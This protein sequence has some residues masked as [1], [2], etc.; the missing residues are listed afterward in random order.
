MR[1]LDLDDFYDR[2]TWNFEIIEARNRAVANDY[3]TLWIGSGHLWP[4]HIYL[5]AELSAPSGRGEKHKLVLEYG[6]TGPMYQKYD[7]YMRE[8]PSWI[9]PN[10]LQHLIGAVVGSDVTNRVGD[11][12]LKIN[13]G[14]PLKMKTEQVCKVMNDFTTGRYELTSCNCWH[15]VAAIF[16]AARDA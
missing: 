1:D 13:G 11:T 16:E 2:S 15:F 8:Y 12:I 9:Q 6:L 14:E 10:P 3:L 4:G 7:A 5:V